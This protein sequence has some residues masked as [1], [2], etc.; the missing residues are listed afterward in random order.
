MF[1]RLNLDLP[2][3]SSDNDDHFCQVLSF[4]SL[5]ISLKD[6]EW[7]WKWNET[8]DL[9]VNCVWPKPSIWNKML[10]CCAL[11]IVWKWRTICQVIFKTFSYGADTK[12]YWRTFI[13]VFH[14]YELLFFFLSHCVVLLFS[15][16]LTIIYGMTSF[17]LYR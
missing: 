15:C 8:V 12:C 3:A 11:H 7:T 2:C 14:V 1:C 6:T 4:K 5:F 10:C 17:V 9:Y 13:P 16:V